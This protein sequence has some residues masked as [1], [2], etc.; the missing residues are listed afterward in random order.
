MATQNVVRYTA[1]IAGVIYGFSHAS[2]LQKKADA[3]YI[4]HASERREKLIE[5]AR[6]AYAQKQI[7]DKKPKSD[8]ITDPEDP[9]FDLEKLFAS[10]EK[11]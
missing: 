6:K 7:D 10:W 8:L 11:A 4:K 2:T 9:K 3:D 1:I 5:Q